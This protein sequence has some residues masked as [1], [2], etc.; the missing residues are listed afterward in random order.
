MREI[1]SNRRVASLFPDTA[2]FLEGGKFLHSDS[3]MLADILAGHGKQ[4]VKLCDLYRQPEKVSEV[5][6]YSDAA[7]VVQTTWLRAERVRPI[8]EAF[9]ATQWV[10]K[11]A[12]FW[13]DWEGFMDLVRRYPDTKV[14]EFWCV[15]KEINVGDV[16]DEV[17]EHRRC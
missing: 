2:I 5:T 15:G 6:Q 12:V 7:I 1:L 3:E 11:M 14:Y 16:N 17:D 8:I 13:H 10:P 9:V 4:V